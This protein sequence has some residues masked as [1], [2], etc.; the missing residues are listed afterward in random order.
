MAVAIDALSNGGPVHLGR[1]DLSTVCQQLA[2]PALGVERCERDR[3][4]EPTSCIER[5][6]FNPKSR[7]TPRL[8]RTLSVLGK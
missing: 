4:V 1:I 7:R 5:E 6:N 3:R 2:H 8:D